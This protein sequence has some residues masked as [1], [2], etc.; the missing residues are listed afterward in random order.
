[1]A[2]DASSPPRPGPRPSSSRQEI[3][4]CAIRMM[5]REGT[6]T[7]S[8]RAMAREL[9]ITTH[10]RGTV[11]VIQGPRFSSRA[12]SRWYSNQGWEVVT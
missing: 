9:G 7:L 12:E 6:E 4:Q 2:I 8:F 11:V 3:V 5:D 1:M 10:E